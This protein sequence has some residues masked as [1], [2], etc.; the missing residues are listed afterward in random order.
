MF[1]IL[2]MAAAMQLPAAEFRASAV[3][4]DITPA[5]VQPLLGYGARNSTGVHDSLFHRIA[6]MD[7][8]DL[9][10]FLVSTDIALIF[11]SV[12]DEFCRDLKSETGIE[13]HQVWWT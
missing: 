4:I 1:L 10:F 12:F 9:Q 3:K 8:G 6:A 11:P 5:N 7:D 2:L 13:A